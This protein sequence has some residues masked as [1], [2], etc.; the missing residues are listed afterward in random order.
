M[1]LDFG[2]CNSR[3]GTGSIAAPNGRELVML[4][5]TS[6]SNVWMIENF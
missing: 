3:P 5:M 6:G 1:A 2:G 4:G